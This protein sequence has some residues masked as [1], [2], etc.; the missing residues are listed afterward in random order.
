MN[1]LAFTQ[2]LELI[3]IAAKEDRLYH[4]NG[5]QAFIRV[6]NDSTVMMII[7]HSTGK[8]DINICDGASYLLHNQGMN[9]QCSERARNQGSLVIQ[10]M[11]SK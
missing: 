6:S 10:L 4:Y 1:D 9:L 5:G 8:L 2:G 11:T 7:D 3:D